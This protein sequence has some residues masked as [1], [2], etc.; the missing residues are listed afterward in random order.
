MIQLHDYLHDNFFFRRKLTCALEIRP[1]VSARVSVRIVAG[2]G[3][4]ARRLLLRNKS[5]AAQIKIARKP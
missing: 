4:S 1:V 5:S 2:I 3:V